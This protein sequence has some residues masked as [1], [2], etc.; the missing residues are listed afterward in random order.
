MGTYQNVVRLK[1]GNDQR[2]IVDAFLV[3]KLDE[4]TRRRVRDGYIPSERACSAVRFPERRSLR[5]KVMK[6]RDSCPCRRTVCLRNIVPAEIAG[7]VH[8]TAS[9]KQ[10][11]RCKI[12]TVPTLPR[13]ID[14]QRVA[15]K[16]PRLGVGHGTHPVVLPCQKHTCPS[17]R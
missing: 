8:G 15:R 7:V 17:L 6:V 4:I 14:E 3:G 5:N 9:C 1:A 11:L 2:V 10:C 12:G 13:K 16:R